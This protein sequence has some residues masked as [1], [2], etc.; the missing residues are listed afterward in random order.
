MGH[1]HYVNGQGKV[2][3]AGGDFCGESKPFPVKPGKHFEVA[4]LIGECPAAGDYSLP[5]EGTITATFSK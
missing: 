5:T 3:E 4:V 2:I 1:V